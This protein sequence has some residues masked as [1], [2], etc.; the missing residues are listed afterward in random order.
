MKTGVPAC[1]LF[2]FQCEETHKR[3]RKKTCLPDFV[4]FYFTC[5]HLVPRI[6][7]RMARLASLLTPT[8][9]SSANVLQASEAKSA[10]E[11]S[12]EQKTVLI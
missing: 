9:T 12:F 10:I 8:T 2:C 1:T 7:A 4:Q 11:V 6:L 5:R 3:T